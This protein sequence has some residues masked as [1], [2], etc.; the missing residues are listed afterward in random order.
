MTA[1]SCADTETSY[2]LRQ[3]M[4]DE[5]ISQGELRDVQWIQV[6]RVVPRHCLVPSYHPMNSQTVVDGADPE[7]TSAW[8]HAIYSDTTLVT[9]RRPDAVTSSGTMPGLIALMLHALDV[10]EGHT[11]L[12]AGTGTGYTAALLSELLGSDHVVSIDID[13]ELTEP[14]QRRLRSC[15]YHPTVVTAD[16][17]VGYSPRAPYDRVMA[18]FA[19][20]SIPPAWLEQTRDGGHLTR[21]SARP[22]P[23]HWRM[24]RSGPAETRGYPA[25]SC[26]TTSS[27]SS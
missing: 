21:R 1:T 2:S 5:L 7:Q 24:G 9:Q 26:G 11:V 13:P 8:L 27:G 17:A 15:G 16:A 25:A 12:Q 4:V 6:F 23:P 22:Y 10:D 3:A 14:A 20:Q 19:V 18:T